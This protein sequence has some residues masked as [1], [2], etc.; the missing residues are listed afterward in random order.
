MS[1]YELNTILKL[2]QQYINYKK[3]KLPPSI[4]SW[5]LAKDHNDI[6]KAYSPLEKA[7]SP[8]IIAYISLR[9]AYSTLR[10]AHSPLRDAYSPLR[11][12]CSPLRDAYS[13]L[14]NDTILSETRTPSQTHMF[15]SEVLRGQYAFLTVQCFCYT[16][17]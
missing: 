11:D 2:I 5:I 13:P 7:Q 15:L 17:C 6:I 10:D 3:Q 1:N 14:R 16:F 8:L 9:D 12:A 4:L